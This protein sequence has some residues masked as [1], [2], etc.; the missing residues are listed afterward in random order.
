MHWILR[1]TNSPELHPKIQYKAQNNC[2]FY[3]FSHSPNIVALITYQ[4][5]VVKMFSTTLTILYS[6]QMTYDQV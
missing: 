2:E 4:L 3:T 1:A 5:E 6:L